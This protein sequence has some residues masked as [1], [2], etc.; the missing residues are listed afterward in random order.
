MA[1]LTQAPKGTKDVLPS[2][3]HK[4]HYV[5]SILRKTAAD[6]GCKEIRFPTFEHTEL[7]ERGVGDT[8]D[9]VQKEMYTF[10][11]KGGR[12]VSLRPEGT[13]SVARA[14]VEH[15]LE[16]AGL[17]V[18]CYYIA[19]NFRYEKPQSGRLREHHQFGVEY[20]G[21]T[22]PYADAEVIGLADTF[23]KR[24]G[25]TGI[26]VNI[27]SVGCPNCRGEYQL[28]LRT[29]FSAHKDELCETCLG[30]LEKNPMRIIDCKSPVCSE[31]AKGAPKTIDF[32]CGDCRE[33]FETLKAL[34]TDM[35]IDYAVDPGIVRGLDYYTRTVFEF[36]SSHIGAQG[37]VC[38]GGRYDKLVSELG[39][40]ETSGLGF[41]SGI[42]RLI[43][44]MEAMGVKFPE[45]EKAGLFIAA[46]GEK[47]KHRAAVLIHS[48]RQEGV[49]AEYDLM[50]RSVKAQMKYADKIGAR[51]S[52]VLGDEELA[53]GT[54]NLKNMMT[55]ETVPVSIS[56]VPGIL[57]AIK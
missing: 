14:F 19:A 46:I 49:S 36:V 57:N 41:G 56:D 21:S 9:I 7:F 25:I 2:E 50:D 20:F 38:G 48:L 47:A 42:E 6:F 24:L 53:N 17:P 43:M 52:L 33:H 37:T 3:V 13:A 12:S 34:L 32:L 11:D 22:S 44:V 40:K 8:T 15:S 27:N 23:I 35:G 39:G 5:E 31:I 4:W 16:G 26:K 45:P 28:A 1:I 29:Y 30:R 55:G 51:Y 18:K 10:L 54:A